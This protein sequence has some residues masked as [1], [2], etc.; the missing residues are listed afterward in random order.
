MK[1]SKSL[2]FQTNN[3]NDNAHCFL[4]M[5]HT[6]TTPIQFG[7]QLC[8]GTIP[9][10]SIF[11]INLFIYSLFIFFLQITFCSVILLLFGFCL[12]D[13]NNCYQWLK[14]VRNFPKLM[15]VQIFHSHC[16]A[17]HFSCSNLS[18][19]CAD[20]NN[21]V[22]KYVR[23]PLLPKKKRKKMYK[24][25]IEFGQIKEYWITAGNSQWRKL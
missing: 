21:M 18:Y 24:I 8:A 13:G 9:F 22:W 17:L 23:T 2:I 6:R 20:F 19:K 11:G 5:Q 15:H 7:P 14:I 10:S 16:I 25:I 12:L 3:E 4:A 1:R